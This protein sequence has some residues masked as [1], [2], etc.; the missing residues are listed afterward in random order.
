MLKDHRSAL[1][2]LTRK[3]LESETVDGEVVKQAL[4]ETAS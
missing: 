2:R 4:A 3:L 1:E